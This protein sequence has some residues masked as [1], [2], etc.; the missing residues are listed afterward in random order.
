MA[1]RLTGAEA[2]AILRGLADGTRRGH[3]NLVAAMRSRDVDPAL[4]ARA[5]RAL[6][7]ANG[8]AF[9]RSCGELAPDAIRALLDEPR[10]ADGRA[11]ATLVFLKEAVPRDA[12]DATLARAWAEALRALLDANTTYAWGSKQRRAKIRGLATSSLLPAIQAVASGCTDV[13]LDLLAVLAADGSE[14]LADALLPHFHR[15]ATSAGG[16]LDLLERLETHAADTPPI[17]AMLAEVQRL[18]ADRQAASPALAVARAIGLGDLDSFWFWAFLG[19]RERNRNN[20]SSVQSNLGIDSTSAT[21]FTVSISIVDPTSSAHRG[22]SFTNERLYRDD[23][24][25]GRCEAPEL[26]SL[27]ARAGQLLSIAWDFDA[28]SPRT[29][30]RGKKRERLVAWMRGA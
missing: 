16:S 19:S 21:W 27:L 5:A 15:A 18:L 8:W 14:A 4:V 20:V 23:L 30:L 3:D 26:P 12:D 10:D 7:A 11:D 29:N 6:M 9:A 24:G 2:E 1:R 17:R 22:T 25:I 28:M 13:P